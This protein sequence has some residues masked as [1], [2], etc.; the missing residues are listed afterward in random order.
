[1]IRLLTFGSVGLQGLDGR[2]IVPVL[3]QPKRLALLIYLTVAR[4]GES[5]RRDHLLPLFWPDLDDAR[6]RDA[7]NQALRFLRQALGPETFARQSAD[8]IGIEPGQIWC[9]AVG[10]QDALDAGRPDEALDLYRGDFLQGYFIEDAAG[11]EEWME[12]ERTA[13]RDAAA[14]GARRLAERHEGAGELTLAISWGQKVLDLTP[15]DERGLRRLLR[16][17]VR[18]GDRVGALRL[19]EAFARRLEREY[20]CPPSPE[21]VALMEEL[22]SGDAESGGDQSK[23]RK[24]PAP[25]PSVQES[26]AAPAD[27]PDAPLATPEALESLSKRYR[28]ERRLGAGGMATVYLARDLKHDRDVALKVLRPDIAEGLARERFLR[29]IRI[30]GRLNHPNIVPLFDSGE[31]GGRLYYV[32]PYVQGETLRERLQ[33]EER[34]AFADVVHLLHEV[35]AALAYAHERGVL[36]RDIKPENIL[37]LDRRAVLSDFGIARAAHAARPEGGAVDQTLTQQ[38]TSLGTPAYMAPEQVAGSAQVDYRADLYST[39]VVGYELLTG[40]PPFT[41]ATPQE[42]LAAQVLETPIPVTDRRPDTPAQLA[43]LVMQCLQ[44][45]PDRRPESAPVLM[46][47]L[48]RVRVHGEQLPGLIRRGLLTP[49]RRTRAFSRKHRRAVLAVG[50][51]L[52]LVVG[53]LAL[54]QMGSGDAALRS[55]DGNRVLVLP[56]EIQ[57]DGAFSGEDAATALTG[58]LNTTDSLIAAVADVGA[59]GV[60]V[61][62][63]DRE[64]TRLGRER[65]ARYVVRGR[66]AMDSPLRIAV[67]VRDLRTGSVQFHAVTAPSGSDAFAVARRVART[68]LPDFIRP[69]GATLDD[70]LLSSYVPALAVYLEGER[71]YRRGDF[72]RADSLFGLAVER[73]SG[74]AWAAFRGAQAA[75]WLTER[76]QAERF[77][78]VAVGAADSFPP[79]YAELAKGLSAHSRGQPDSAVG[80]LRR[81]LALDHRWAEAHMALGEVYHH[82]VPRDRYPFEAGRAA[83]DSALIYDPGFVAP[84]FHAIQ[85]AVWRGDRARANELSRRLPEVATDPGGQRAQ[86][87]LMRG[88][89]DGTSTRQRWD[90]A[91]KSSVSAATQAVTW[92]VVGGM[93]HLQCAVDGLEAIAAREGTDYTW[94]YYACLELA[95]IHAARGDVARVRD[96]LPLLGGMTDVMT[97]F[98][99]G[100][101]L[102]IA[103]LADTALERLRRHPDLPENPLRTWATATWALEQGDTVLAISM[104]AQL[105]RQGLAPEERTARLMH[106]SL[107]ARLT[108]FRG[109]TA[110]A[111]ATLRELRP[112][113]DQRT[114]RWSPWEALP[115]ERMKLVQ[116]LVARGQL[117]DAAATASEFDSPAS[118]GYVPWL[119]ASLQLREELERKLGDAPYADELRRR[120]QGL[121][122]AELQ[123]NLLAR[124]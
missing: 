36:H 40:R 107:V 28:I 75:S 108:L 71:S 15:D 41:G 33:R 22:R 53:A 56:M 101:G 90:E 4:P 52:G 120:Y 35:G 89:I 99:A 59:A 117:V 121:A 8:A 87:T 72:G 92:L 61:G 54:S 94:Y 67:E 49:F 3:A 105:A 88:C 19:Y 24:A 77:L 34:F 9:D 104:Q 123:S 106:A 51:G 2:A 57:G 109:D 86:L 30:A 12:R 81:A 74:F 76:A 7:L 13:Y 78:K 46:A 29:E 20:D 47:G 10:F 85:H 62:W 68:I 69:G 50:I 65:R 64:V 122:Q 55:L 93:R 82:Y 39:G 96:L 97:I 5:H 114:L 118:F 66:I 110:A 43:E 95:F 98:L 70:R 16:L 124:R 38:G 48:E 17:H 26:A 83:F 113:A 63:P 115:W 91:A 84:L 112:T 79:R 25:S 42:I 37:L 103:G 27:V 1:M 23:P 31:D 116:L 14:K 44:K 73:D 58:T 119:P 45:D 80:H 6:A 60:P 32:M 21:T 111:I 102:P 18:A 11:F 100:S